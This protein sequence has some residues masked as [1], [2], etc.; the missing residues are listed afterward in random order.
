MVGST[1]AHRAANNARVIAVARMAKIWHVGITRTSARRSST[2]TIAGL[3]T[4]RRRQINGSHL[5]VTVN[6]TGWA[7][8]ETLSACQP[9]QLSAVASGSLS[10]W[11]LMMKALLQ[12]ASV[13]QQLGQLA[14]P[15]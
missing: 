4:R 13:A 6:V 10:M 15:L 5:R 3:R 2:R 1:R 8:P 9:Q 12:D 14:S 11:Q 7:R